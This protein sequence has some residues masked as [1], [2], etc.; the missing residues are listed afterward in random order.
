ML[1][2]HTTTTTQGLS[3]C[4]ALGWLCCLQG[5]HH[6]KPIHPSTSMHK[7]AQHPPYE[8]AQRFTSRALVFSRIEWEL[9][10]IASVKSPL[11]LACICHS[12][13]FPRLTLRVC[14]PTS[15]TYM[16]AC[17]HTNTAPLTTAYDFAPRRVSDSP[18]P[19][20]YCVASQPLP[21]L[22]RPGYYRM[23]EPQ[24]RSADNNRAPPSF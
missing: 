13:P 14:L 7:T 10:R 23:Q 22:V 15:F 16:H 8:T 9:T 21:K 12:I 18:P 5:P 2:L 19:L 4:F 1:G 3:A 24:L 20:L 17:V 11:A 6:N